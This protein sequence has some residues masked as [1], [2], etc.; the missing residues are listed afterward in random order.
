MKKI[1]ILIPVYN[2]WESL[3]AL[4]KDINSEIQKINNCKFSCLIVNDAST[5][6]APNLFK[7][8]YLE[9]LTLINMKKT[10]ATKGV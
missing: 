8:I 1:V 9:N 2:D 10:Q 7:P 6:K 4:L 5:V 3:L